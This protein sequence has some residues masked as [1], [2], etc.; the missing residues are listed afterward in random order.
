[1]FKRSAAGSRVKLPTRLIAV[2]AASENIIKIQDMEGSEGGDWVALSYQ[3]GAPPHFSTTR[4]NLKE[5]YA[6]IDIDIL[7]QT[8]KDAIKVTRA[9]QRP[10]LWIDSLCIIQGPGGDFDTEAT[11]MEDVFNGAYC[12]LAACCAKDQ[13]SGFLS[14]RVPRQRVTLDPQHYDYG[15]IHVCP[16]IENF[17]RH[18]LAGGL[19]QRGWVLQEHALARRTIFFTKYQTYWECGHGVR[20]ETM[21]TLSK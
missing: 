4:Q 21:A 12:V 3:W 5:M 10:Y 6:G 19:A 9:L 7:P 17:G 18:V 8:F 1:M 14:A 15:A 11:T 2:S 16:T 20:C 13:R